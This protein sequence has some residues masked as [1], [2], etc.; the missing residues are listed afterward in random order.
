MVKVLMVITKDDV[1]GAQKYVRDLMENLDKAQFEAKIITGGKNGVYFLSNSLKPHF[2]FFNDLAA[3]VELFFVFR[4]EQPDIIH[5]NSSK[6]GVVGALAACLYKL[7][8]KPKSYNLKVKVIF[9][10]HGWVFNPDNNLSG[11]RRRFYILLHRFAAKFQDA[12]I[13]VS[14]Y[15]RQLAIK[16]KIAS[17]QKLFTVHNGIDIQSVKFFDRDVARQTLIK[18]LEIGNWKLEINGTWI[19]SIGRLVSE[20]SYEDFVRAAALVKNS[21][22]NFFIFGDGYERQKLQSLIARHQLQ[23]RFFLLG[24]VADAARHLKAFDV[25]ILSSVKEGL[26]YTM[27]E[28]M[29]AS[30]PMITTRVGGMTEVAEGRGLVMPPRESAELARAIDFYL[31]HPDK[32]QESAKNGQDFLVQN[33][34]LRKMVRETEKIYLS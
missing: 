33:L 3:A 18:K 1:G 20:K 24:A 6:A 14:E 27:L 22:A 5:L 16:E 31:D 11:L 30:L 19:G 7:F 21:K 25:F 28:A 32:A 29:A 13:N 26:P 8:L 10:A 12:I 2:L 9:T 15:D 17:S 34:T 23:D 4:R